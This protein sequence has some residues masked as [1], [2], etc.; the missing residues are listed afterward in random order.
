VHPKSDRP[1]FGLREQWRR[2]GN[3][4]WTVHGIP[5]LYFGEEIEFMKG[6]PQ[7]IIGNDD[8]LETTGRAY[9]GD[10]IN[11]EHIAA[12][13]NHP[14]YKHIQRLNRIH[15][16]IPAYAMQGPHEPHR[17]VGLR[18]LLRPRLEPG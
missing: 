7:D 2:S 16:A 14:L 15:R 4:L 11:D 9:F 10:H 12:T 3:L 8:T 5:C 1:H 6:A 17:R 13:R 18:H